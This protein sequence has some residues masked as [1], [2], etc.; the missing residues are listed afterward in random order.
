MIYDALT[1]ELLVEFD[2]Y[3]DNS[4]SNQNNVAFEPLENGSFSSDSK[5]V[6]PDLIN[7]IGIKS[8]NNPQRS[9]VTVGQVKL[10]LDKLNK[11]DKIVWV[12]IEPMIDNSKSKD[13]QYYQYGMIYKNLT[14]FNLSWNNNPEQLELRANMTFQEVRLTN[15][16]YA[17]QQN[18][19]NPQDK[20]VANAGQVQ[21]TTD[22]SVLAKAKAK[23]GL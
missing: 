9:N 3:I 4:Y 5:Q 13:S 18:V 8:I 2:T 6:T 16:E 12:K 19:A 15:S 21:P 17:K 1:S 22:V 10:A 20:P 7:I 11:S 23:L 14:L